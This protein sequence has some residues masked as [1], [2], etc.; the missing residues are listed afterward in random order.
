MPPKNTDLKTLIGK[1]DNAIQAIKELFEEFEEI[2]SVQPQLERLQSTFNIIEAKYRNIKK[3]QEIIADK[4]I[5]DGVAETDQLLSANQKVGESL[6]DTYLKVAKVY[7][8]YQKSPTQATA[9]IPN[10]LE[11]MSSAVTKMAE[12]LQATKSDSSRGLE[13]LPVPTWD[14]TRRSYKTWKREFNHWLDKY[15]QDKDEQLQRFRKAMPKGFWWTDQAR[16]VSPSIV[17]GKS[18]ISSSPTKGN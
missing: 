12:A 13:R 18:L 4:I 10:S 1:R 7:A 17:L 6:K 2:Y 3:Q 15:S 5:E 8:A 9:T 11:V 16:V 14:G